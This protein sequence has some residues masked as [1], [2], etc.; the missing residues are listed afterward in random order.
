M[1][2]CQ[3]DIGSCNYE[4]T[5]HSHRP[6]KEDRIFYIYRFLR[7]REIRCNSGET[8]KDR[9]KRLHTRR[10]KA[11]PRFEL[12][13]LDSKSKVVTTGLWGHGGG[14]P[15]NS[16]H[17]PA[18]TRWSLYSIQIVVQPQYIT[19][20]VLYW[21]CTTICIEYSDTASVYNSKGSIRCKILSSWYW[22]KCLESTKEQLSKT[23]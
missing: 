2:H 21:G 7:N 18:R 6:S 15:K 9:I 22:Y 5:L 17:V 13:F 4:Q 12:G 23:K 11:P 3:V 19:R 14:R 16:L 1:A 20:R 8:W 10:L